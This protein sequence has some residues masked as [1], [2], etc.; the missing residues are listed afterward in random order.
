MT[1]EPNPFDAIDGRP[2]SGSN[3]PPPSGISRRLNSKPAEPEV[4][5]APNSPEAEAGILG[6]ILL[7][8]ENSLGRCEE[9]LSTGDLYDLRHRDLLEALFQMRNDGTPIDLITLSDR[10]KNAGKLDAIGGLA[11]LS[12]LMESTPSAGNLDYYL[13]I[14]SEKAVQRKTLQTAQL[15]IQR[16]HDSEDS[17]LVLAQIERDF[18][19]VRVMQ[20]RA[21]ETRIL[22]ARTVAG[23]FINWCETRA[24]TK[25]ALSGIA[26]GFPKF[27]EMTDGIQLQEL[28]LI[29]ARPGTG[30]TSMAIDIATHVAINA[31]HPRAVLF[32]SIEMSPRS[33]VR[34]MTS[35]LSRV[36]MSKMKD[37]TYGKNG[38]DRRMTNATAR[39]AAAPIYFV[40][41]IGGINCGEIAGLITAAKKKHGVELVIVDYIQKVRPTK[42][43]SRRDLEIAE[44]SE[45]LRGAAHRN[46]VACLCL[47]Q[48]RRE[49][50]NV[51]T[52]GRPNLASLR[53]SGN[54]EQ[55]ADLVA[56]LV[57]IAVEEGFDASNGYPMELIVSKQRDGATGMVQL[58]FL[59]QFCHFES[60]SRAP[61]S[62]NPRPAKASKK[63]G[64]TPPEGWWNDQDK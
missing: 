64:A 21:S 34:R 16:V 62:D 61:E 10:L 55:D 14:V 52:G 28:A 53:E 48:L 41:A 35:A 50:D 32:I 49:Q 17:G 12:R 18:D 58:T 8:P 29:A 63:K 22:D 59:P 36:S 57:K 9:R 37:G 60:S 19:A 5:Q 24:L 54:L 3:N 25:G 45:T 2:V 42:I 44:V 46:H 26:T 56:F 33:L 51:K 27:D 40:D 1:E 20:E 11:F 4:R 38:E 47:A 39:I 31:E 6:C 30:K 15:A 43:H 13:E 7:D 23:D